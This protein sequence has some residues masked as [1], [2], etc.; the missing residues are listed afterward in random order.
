M[1][2]YSSKDYPVIQ[3]IVDH[4]KYEEIDEGIDQR[5]R[6]FSRNRT[7]DTLLDIFNYIRD[8]A[9]KISEVKSNIGDNNGND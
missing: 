2:Y 3:V 5:I 4:N 9:I 6:T 8:N 7:N 1:T